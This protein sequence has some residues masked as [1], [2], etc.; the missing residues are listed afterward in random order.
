MLKRLLIKLLQWEIQRIVQS[1]T[2]P[3]QR[4]LQQLRDRVA[5]LDKHAVSLLN[6][7]IKNKMDKPEG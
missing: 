4:E 7:N 3:L 5:E 1:Q 2:A 6:Q